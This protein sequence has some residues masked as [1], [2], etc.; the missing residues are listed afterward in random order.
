MLPI[1]VVF[2]LSI[3]EYLVKNVSQIDIFAEQMKLNMCN[4]K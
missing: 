1:Y 2:L 4:H 3:E